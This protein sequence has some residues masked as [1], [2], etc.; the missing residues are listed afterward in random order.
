VDSK[1]DTGHE[2]VTR[3]RIY[4]G[5]MTTTSEL[6]EKKTYLV[7]NEDTTARTLVIEHP[8]RPEWKL[9]DDGPKP[10]EKAVGLYRFRV[11]VDPKKT[12]RLVINEA[13]PLYTQFAMNEITDDQI[14]MFLFQKSINSEIEKSLRAIVAQKNVVADLDAKIKAQQ[15]SIDQIFTDQGR[16]RENMK[17][18][19]GSAEEKALLQRYTRQ[20]DDE[21]T[22]L[23][24]LRKR[25]QDTE[26]E[27]QSANGALQKMIQELQMDVTL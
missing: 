3:T 1:L 5:T 19:K 15:K 22:Q 17:A 25:K 7:R 11:N 2:R 23:D 10:E 4:R 21:E 20:L 24:A 13:K 8:A 26:A 16:L 14:G 12:E 9:S 6:R 27:Q 18:L